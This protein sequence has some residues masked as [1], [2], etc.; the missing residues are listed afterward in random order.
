MK[1]AFVNSKQ[2]QCGVY[3]WG[4]LVSNILTLDDRY[5]IDYIECDCI[6]D[7]FDSILGKHHD[8]IFYNWHQLT[9]KWLTPTIVESLKPY[10]K[11]IFS[12]HEVK[13]PYQ[14]SPDALLMLDLSENITKREF[15]IPR[16]IIECEIKS[17]KNSEFTIGS[18][19]FGIENK[20]FP[21]LCQWVNDNFSGA[22]LKLHITNAYWG[23]KL[24]RSRDSVINKCHSIMSRGNN[25]LLVTSEFLDNES[26]LKF[27]A[28]N[29]LNVFLYD[30]MPG[31]GLSSVI[32][33]AISVDTPILV[34]DSE[35]FRHLTS[36]RPDMSILNFRGDYKKLGLDSIKYFREKWSNQN[37]RDKFYQLLTT[38]R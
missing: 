11:Q 8:F 34:N 12:F 18:F 15:S 36:E 22:H 26:L 5:Q 19:G 35:M 37:L 28:Q 33:W 20:G 4:K 1:V 7:F 14:F 17:E 30:R 9:Q 38:I 25:T 32:D 6:I 23:D 16:P 24:A 31:R 10:S 3:Q 27:L 2:Q 21:R 13:K 29:D